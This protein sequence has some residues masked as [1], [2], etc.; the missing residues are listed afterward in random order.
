MNSNETTEMNKN[1]E[2][3]QLDFC[4]N[5]KR[6]QH[7]YLVDKYGIES[8]YFMTFNMVQ[9]TVIYRREFKHVDVIANQDGLEYCLCKNC[10]N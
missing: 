8:P 4:V 2:E 1:E 7:P 9:S 3:M 6:K 5:C 10:E